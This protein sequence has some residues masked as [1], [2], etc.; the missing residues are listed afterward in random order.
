MASSNPFLT[1]RK[2]SSPVVCYLTKK[3]RLTLSARGFFALEIRP[4]LFIRC[5]ILRSGRRYFGKCR[6]RKLRKKWLFSRGVRKI[7]LASSRMCIDI[8]PHL[9]WI[10]LSFFGYYLVGLTLGDMNAREK[11]ELKLYVT[12]EGWWEGSE[13]RAGMFFRIYRLYIY[14][15]YVCMKQTYVYLYPD[16]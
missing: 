12:Q 3:K 15:F 16:I 8:T 1:L 14:I 5:A 11:G 10:S 13:G 2:K 6:K 7:E 9:P 4:C